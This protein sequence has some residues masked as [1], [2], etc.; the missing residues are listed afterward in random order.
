[1]DIEKLKEKLNIYL[2][3]NIETM[4]WAIKSKK[5]VLVENYFKGICGGLNLALC[6]IKE[7]EEE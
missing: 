7:L 5:P 6:L 1:M 3:S 2:N 4:E